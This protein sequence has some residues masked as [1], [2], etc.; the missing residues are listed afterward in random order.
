MLAKEKT[1]EYD[2]SGG[3]RLSDNS[4]SE[5]DDGPSTSS[6][7]IQNEKK[8]SSHTIT[9]SSTNK[10]SVNSVTDLKKIHDNL[11]LMEQARANMMKYEKKPSSQEENVNI[12]DL[13]AMGETAQQETS[14]NKKS[15]QRSRNDSDS[16]WEEVE[17]KRVKVRRY[18][19]ILKK[20]E[21][22]E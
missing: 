20:F 10:T 6:K 19:K 3:L 9:S 2:C 15:S 7:A 14:T 12:A 8:K 21:Y 4:D 13:L 1:P 17:G 16:E 11:Q 5:I 18:L 22:N